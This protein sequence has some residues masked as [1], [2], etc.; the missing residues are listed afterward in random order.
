MGILAASHVVRM[1]FR[2]IVLGLVVAAGVAGGGYAVWREQQKDWLPDGFAAANGRVEATQIEIAT[3]LP[4]QLLDVNVREGDDVAAGQVLARVESDEVEAQLRG[5]ESEVARLRQGLSQAEAELARLHSQT[6]YERGELDR[7]QKVFEKGFTSKDKLE[8]QQTKYASAQSAERA[9]RAA[10]DGAADAINTAQAEIDRLRSLLVHAEL[11]APKAARVQYR[12]AEPGEILASGGRVLTLLDLDDVYMTV[13]LSAA[14]AG[15]LGIG[16]EA[17]LVMD[18]APEYVFPAK[19][20]FVAAD[21]QFT[22]KSVETE[23]ERAKLMF[24]VKLVVDRDL[25]QRF[26]AQVKPG[27][28][29]VAYVKLRQD[30]EWPAALA[31]NL[32]Q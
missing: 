17:R 24:R 4:G 8:A 15:R 11:K 21:A 9:A 7:V 19:V 22:P 18:A 32:P 6:V 25:V 13:F 23:E 5:A 29:G 30:A 20:S 12:L 1:Q 31:P 27:L 3:K 28:R 14:D 16:S 10:A 26:R 2:T